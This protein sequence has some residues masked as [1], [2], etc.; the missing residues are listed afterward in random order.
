MR[1]RVYGMISTQST[2]QEYLDEEQCWQAVM[3]RKREADG[4]FIVAVR[5]T[6]IYCRPSCPA[7]HP[8][9]EHVTFFRLPEEAQAAGYRPCRRCK[10]EQI[11]PVEPNAELIEQV[12]RYIETHLDGP[13]QLTNLS[14]Q[15]HLSPY[16]LQRTFKRIKGLTPRQY[17]ESCRLEQFKAQLRQ[18]ES[19]TSALY[20]AG[21]QSSSR[22]YERAAMQLGMT[23]QTYRRGGKGVQM[24]YA[25]SPCP[26]GYVLL[27]ATERG[28]AAVRM[29]DDRKSLEADL[30]H[31]YPEATLRYDE[32][33]LSNWMQVLLELLNG[34]PATTELPLDIQGTAF[35]WKVWQALQ[36][37][38]PGET[39]SYQ[40]IAQAIGAPK[41]SRA[42]A[43]ACAANPVAV[44]IPCHRVVRNNGESG[45]YRWGSERKRKILSL[46]KP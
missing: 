37:I 45:G 35:Q 14:Q 17:A 30:H 36:R 8:R 44:I 11:T 32:E 33:Q 21:Y 19:V 29:G 1:E 39:R 31:E 46:E 12:C 22:V 40:E 42:V 27:A 16:H 2:E 23:P 4:K 41:A 3:A 38:P 34:Q 25:I 6:G 18:G 43:N 28:I 15:F 9:R 5:S 7:R 20:N 26:V 10:P 24:S 13:L